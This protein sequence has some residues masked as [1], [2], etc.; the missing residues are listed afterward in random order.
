MNAKCLL[1]VLLCVALPVAAQNIRAGLSGRITDPS[2]ATVASAQVTITNDGTNQRR[3]VVASATG[4]YS[5][6]QLEPGTY[7]VIVELT[8]FRREVVRKLILETGQ[9]VRVDVSLQVGAVS[10][11]VEVEAAAP[12]V[13]S[14]NASTGGVVEQRKIVELPLNGRNYLQL[15]TLEANVLPAAQGSSNAS[16]GGLNIAGGSEVSNLFIKDGINNNSA[17][18]GSTH[19]PILDSVREFKVLTGT[20]S[21]EFGRQSGAQIMVT[22]KAG[23]NDYHG[24]LWEFHRNSVLD[25]RNFF[26]PTK[27]SFRR[28]QFGGLLSGKI[29]KDKTFF[30]MGYEGNRRGQQDTTLRALPPVAFRNGNFSSLTTPIRNP[31]GGNVPFPGNII[32]ASSF[33][34]QGAGLLALYPQPTNSGV[35]NFNAAAASRFTSEQFIVRGDHRFSDRDSFYLVYEFQDSGTVTPFS[36]VGLPGYGVLASSGTQHAVAS[37]LHVFSPSLIAEA[38]AGYSRLKVLNVQEDYQVDVVKRLGIQGLTDAGRTPFNN[39]APSLTVAGYSGIGGGT[40]QP[41]GRGE[42]THQ[43]VGAM[44]WIHGSHSTKWG[45]DYFTFPYN[46]F[47]TSFGRGSFQFDGRFSGNSVADLLLGIPFRADR[48]LGE[49]FHNS[50]VNSTGFYFQDD[51]KV[52]PKLTVNLGLRYDLFPAIYERVNKLSSWDPRTNTIRVAGGREAFLSPTGQLLLRDRPDVGRT[53][54]KTDYNNISPR[55]GFAYRPFGKTSTVIR[56]GFGSFYNMQSA[57]NGITPLSRSSPFREAQIAGPFSAPTIPDLANMFTATSSTPVAP[58][59]QEDI[60]TG[61]INQW[62]FGVQR[63]LARNLVLDVSY[64]GSQGHKLPTAWNLNQSLPGAGSV[65]ARRPYQ[66]WGGISSGFGSSIGNSAFNSMTVR[67]ERRFASG[68]SF[69]SSYSYSKIIDQT[70][71]VATSSTASPVFAQDARN[72]R[73]ERSVADYDTPH[74][75]VLSSVYTLPFGKGQRFATNQRAIDAIAGGWQMTAIMTLQSGRPF[76]VTSGRDE[77]NTDGGADRPNVIGNWRVAN[78]TPGRWFNP[79]TLTAAGVRRNCLADD[80]PAWQIN[81]INTFGN[82]GR[83]I[84]RGQGSAN[85]DLGIYRNL[86]IFERLSAQ[87]RAEVY[88]VANRAQ[89]LLPVGNAAGVTFGQVTSAAQSDFGAQRQI[90]FALKLTF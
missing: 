17:S 16:R 9:N 77:S 36:G 33:S 79:C 67:L 40:S 71:G 6:P 57:G 44:T 11:S 4:E 8:G 31:R 80:V 55:I 56:A 60:K 78:P 41:Q 34:P 74:R 24:S 27:P 64:L 72:L 87:I 86:R 25:A 32:P 49:P 58:G 75:W 12:L 89:F 59:I 50:V 52:T 15:A 23:T 20:Y 53:I 46:S 88:N 1:T 90:Q 45:G 2:G 62:S 42:N 35:N 66:G 69:L 68:L 43:Y 13:N 85:F 73:S 22:T 5:A 63:E 3:T 28:N 14:D 47:N 39:G 30:M 54:Y 83:N 18:S 19:T 65:A 70:S 7:T 26:A 37:W 38:R 81:A 10:E 76:T 61:Y 21:A 82:A 84:L 51:W 29:W 48:T